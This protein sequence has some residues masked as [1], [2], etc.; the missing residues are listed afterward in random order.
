MSDAFN[1][2]GNG[3]HNEEAPE[4]PQDSRF[5]FVTLIGRANVGKSTLL[6]RFVGEKVSIVSPIPQTTRRRIL[7]VRTLPHGQIAFLDTPGFHKPEHHMGQLM[8]ETARQTAGEADVLVLMIDASSGIGP[9]DRYV[10]DHID[11]KSES[12]PVIIAL[13]KVDLINKAKVLP[14]IEELTGEWGCHHVVPISAETGANCEHLLEV[15]LSFL[16]PGPALYPEDYTTDQDDRRHTAE[17]IREK[18]LHK[19]RQEVPH[20]VAV[21][22]E[23][24]EVRD[25]ELL[26]IL[27]AVMVERE[28]QKGIVIG[29]RGAKLKEV[30]IEAREEL[31]RYFG[32]KIFLKLWVKV[33]ED[34]RD[35]AAILRD[36]GIMPGHQ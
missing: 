15:I 22:V 8:V 27:A 16:P 13:N 5:G 36:L 3:L 21:I 18:L 20:A 32:R 10:L 4:S 7:G 35:K 9:G 34:W 23:S 28:S 24:M 14:M 19:L 2:D 12:R 6:N 33:R 31:E 11:P 1:T 30:G 25:D 26:E 29:H 17:V